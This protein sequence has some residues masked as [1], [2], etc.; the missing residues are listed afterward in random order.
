MLDRKYALWL[1]KNAN[2]DDDV[3]LARIWDNLAMIELDESKIVFSARVS[4][5]IPTVSGVLQ[6]RTSMFAD[7]IVSEAL[8]QLRSAAEEA[9]HGNGAED[10]NSPS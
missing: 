10:P 4:D 6:I 7:R 1:P 9:I 8:G 5:L 3:L 2:G